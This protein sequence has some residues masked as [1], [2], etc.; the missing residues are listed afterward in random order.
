M[1]R[2][3]SSLS[4]PFLVLVSVPLML[5][6]AITTTLAF[7]ILFFRISIVYAELV[8]ALAQA[9]LLPRS[10]TTELTWPKSPT[11][12]RSPPSS[13]RTSRQSSFNS[14]VHIRVPTI[15]RKTRSSVTLA[16]GFQTRDY[17]GLGGWR[18]QIDDDDEAI[19]MG[20]NR[21]LE[22]YSPSLRRSRLAGSRPTSGHGSPEHGRTPKIYPA[23]C[24]FSMPSDGV[25]NS[26]VSFSM[27]DESTRRQS[28]ASLA[29]IT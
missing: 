17:E 22:L 9:Y 8:A 2:L 28:V 19:W 5:F 13:R 20:M 24:Y 29:S 10:I 4:A 15:A 14:G 27:D 7:W 18:V 21:R 25:R 11:V 6:A 26:R 3:A 16:D 1:G 12:Q 23:E